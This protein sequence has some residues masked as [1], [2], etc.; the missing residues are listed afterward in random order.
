MSP[1]AESKQQDSLR[2]RATG[3]CA[4]KSTRASTPRS[5][6]HSSP[7]PAPAGGEH[8]PRPASGGT[9]GC[10]GPDASHGRIHPE[11][12]VQTPRD[13]KGNCLFPGYLISARRMLPR[14]RGH[15]RRPRRGG[16]RR[17]SAAS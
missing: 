4:Q 6:D 17:C 15:A 1:T 9:A 14:R 7:L 16:I 11:P 3:A 8:G 12:T 5:A 10:G 2:Q 13:T